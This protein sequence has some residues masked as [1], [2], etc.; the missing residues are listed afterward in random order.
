MRVYFKLVNYDAFLIYSA[1]LVLQQ[2]SLA[3]LVKDAVAAQ[4][5]PDHSFFVEGVVLAAAA[6]DV[7]HLWPSIFIV[8]VSLHSVHSLVVSSSRLHCLLTFNY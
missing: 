5:A 6:T 3:L 2:L 8:R 7:V 1:C 4:I